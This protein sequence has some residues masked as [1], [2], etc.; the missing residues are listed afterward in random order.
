[1]K[2]TANAK[3]EVGPT[4][5]TEEEVTPAMKATANAKT[6]VG[7]DGIPVELLKF[8]QK[9][10]QT[11]LNG[12]PPTN[13]SHTS[14]AREKSHSSGKTWP[15]LCSTRKTNIRTAETTAACRTCPTRAR[16]SLKWLPGDLK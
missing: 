13:H 9:Q 10:D 4:E 11:V 14:G 1:M 7:P 15:L 8:G 12:V 6:E 16:Y 3:T 2:A 5:P